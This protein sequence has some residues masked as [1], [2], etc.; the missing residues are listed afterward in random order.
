M[1]KK[2]PT[3]LPAQMVVFGGGRLH[4]LCL[5]HFR[6]SVLA[7]AYALGFRK[8]DVAPSYGNGICETEVGIAL[9]GKRL[10]CEINTKY[11]IPITIYGPSS[12]HIFP[13]RRLADIFTCDSASAYRRREFSARDLEKSLH[14]SLRRLGTD[15]VDT[16]FVHEPLAPLDGRELDGIAACGERLKRQGKIRSFGIAGPLVSI[17]Q[18]SSLAL[19]D[20]VQL[21]CA[22]L[23]EAATV[24]ADKKVV[25]YGAY[26]AYRR[27]TPEY[28]FF[29]FVR[30]AL[31]KRPDTSV[32]V[33]STSVETIR[34]FGSLLT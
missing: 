12:R 20:V 28:S 7:E 33:A 9:R 19:F 34:T 27:S 3:A 22:D 26:R 18:C 8:F 6:Q 15:Y 16:L 14:G 4:R 21:P 30:A 23:N 11:G 1:S 17:R 10:S 31:A 25:L 32:I 24:L 2:L 5:A 13:F 29:E